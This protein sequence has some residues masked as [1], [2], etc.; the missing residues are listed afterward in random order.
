MGGG[1]LIFEWSLCGASVCVGVGGG[2]V[3]RID[4]QLNRVCCAMK[5]TNFELF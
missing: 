5:N 2:V 1:T 3:P 4:E